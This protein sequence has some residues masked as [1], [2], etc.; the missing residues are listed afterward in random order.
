MSFCLFVKMKSR[1]RVLQLQMENPASILKTWFSPTPKNVIH[2]PA[3]SRNYRLS[4]QVAE[5][6]VWKKHKS[7]FLWLLILKSNK[8]IGIF[9]IIKHRQ[10]SSFML[11]SRKYFVHFN[12]STIY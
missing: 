5:M 4:F 11:Y 12:I 8:F 1:D 6:H 7:G 3:L 10:S 2:A 9:K